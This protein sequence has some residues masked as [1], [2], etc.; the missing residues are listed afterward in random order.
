LAIL[1][2]SFF[3]KYVF[4]FCHQLGSYYFLLLNFTYVRL[5][6]CEETKQ[7]N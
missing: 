1:D 6:N 4:Y 7:D 2:L 5:I 3:R